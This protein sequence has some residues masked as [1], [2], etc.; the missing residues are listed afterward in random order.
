MFCSEGRWPHTPIGGC[1][2]RRVLHGPP[3]SV[4]GHKMHRLPVFIP[5]CLKCKFPIL[6]FMLGF[7]IYGNPSVGRKGLRPQVFPIHLPPPKKPPC[8]HPT[9]F[10]PQMAMEGKNTNFVF[11]NGP[12]S[13]QRENKDSVSNTHLSTFVLFCTLDS[14]RAHVYLSAR[15]VLSALLFPSKVKWQNLPK[16]KFSQHRRTAILWILSAFS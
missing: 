8:F 14:R 4:S 13:V 7:Q 2:T 5:C 12:E 1:S 6:L 15:L 11:G 3:S 16:W 10:S 9:H